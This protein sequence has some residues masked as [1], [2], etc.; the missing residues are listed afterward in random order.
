MV[1]EATNLVKSYRRGSEEIRALAGVTFSIADGAFVA[2]TG[3]SG[4]GKSTLLQLIGAMD[5]PTSGELIVDACNLSASNDQG[6]T[7]FRRDRIGFVFQDFGLLPTL[8]VEENVRL[9]LSLGGKCAP[10][11]VEELLEL[12]G[13]SSRRHHRPAE[14]SGGEMQ[15][16]AIARSLVRRPRILL[17]DEPTGNLDTRT[18]AQILGILQELNERHGVTVVVVTHSDVLASAAELRLSLQDGRLVA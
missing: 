9:P 11:P 13:L 15:R 10:W 18:G 6:R 1:I 8:T 3:P 16:V 2:V 7:R 5:R 4:S 12:V 17:A 14:L